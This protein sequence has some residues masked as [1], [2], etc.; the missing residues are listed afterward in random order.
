MSARSDLT[1][2]EESV[3]NFAYGL[4]TPPAILV[5]DDDDDIR[6]LMAQ[7]L[8]SQGY[9]VTEAASASEAESSVIKDPPHLI[10]MDLSMP[11]TDGLSSIWNIRKEAG[12]ATVPI[13]IVS[14]YDAFDLRAEATAAGCCGYITKP[15]DPD[16]L[17]T[18][19][20]SVLESTY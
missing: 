11:G 16:Q 13:I 9:S 8:R 6:A 3:T 14:A 19:I 18:T 20:K 4:D 17:K 12:M 1:N 5:V 2:V 7:L 15:L 10:L